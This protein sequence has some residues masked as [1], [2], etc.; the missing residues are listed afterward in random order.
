VIRDIVTSHTTSSWCCPENTNYKPS[1]RGTQGIRARGP[2]RK[3]TTLRNANG[4]LPEH[5][6][7]ALET[8]FTVAFSVPCES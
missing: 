7:P 4:G 5:A 8:G 6:H 3:N 1:G 2:H